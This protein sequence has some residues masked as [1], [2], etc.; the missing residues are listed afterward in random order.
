M[1]NHSAI[2]YMAFQKLKSDLNGIPI[3]NISE[4]VW[5]FGLPIYFREAKEQKTLTEST[6]NS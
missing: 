2:L 1:R 3:I 5:K 6:W 4:I